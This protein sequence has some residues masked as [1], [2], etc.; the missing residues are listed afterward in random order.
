MRLIS[1]LSKATCPFCF[2][3]FHPRQAPL[4][5]ID[6]KGKLFPD[7]HVQDFLSL[8]DAPSMGVVHPPPGGLLSWFLVDSV[9][10]SH[11]R[12]ICPTCHMMLPHRLANGELTSEVFAIIGEANSGKS[13][14]FGVLLKALERRYMTEVGFTFLE[15][16][17][18]LIDELRPISTRRLCS[19]RYWDQLYGERGPHAV[20][21]TQ[22][23]T[24]NTDLRIPLIYRLQFPRRPNHRFSHPFS[25][26]VSVDLVIFDAAGEDMHDETMLGQFYRFIARATGIL[27][28][29]DPTQYPGIR[30]KMDPALRNRLP[31]LDLGHDPSGVITRVANLI[32]ERSGRPAGQKISAPVAVALSKSDLL[33]GLL[34]KGSPILKDSLHQ[35]GFDVDDFRQLD[36]EVRQRVIDWDS[37]ARVTIAESLFADTGFFAVSALGSLPDR[38]TMEIPSLSPCRVADPLLWLLWKHGYLGPKRRDAEVV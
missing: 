22:S 13:N 38:T 35:G 29:I 1:P 27:F 15:Q 21:Q 36:A 8:N 6:P 12:K 23:A 31:A 24:T 10:H 5:S 7:K 9:R 14:Y 19:I 16:E 37:P 33:S 30:S 34:Y 11:L 2:E 17:T 25:K 28:L 20:S 32:Q 26:T 18:F 3:R 4:R